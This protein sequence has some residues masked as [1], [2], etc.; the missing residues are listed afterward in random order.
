MSQSAG[1]YLISGA[2]VATANALSN[3]ST[4]PP[5]R[6]DT[7]TNVKFGSL[8]LRTLYPA[9]VC[10]GTFWPARSVVSSRCAAHACRRSLPPDR[11]LRP[12]YE[13]SKI[14]I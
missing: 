12:L 13:S 5:G 2:G 8:Q 7:A 3:A 4:S 11:S 6:S 10:S 1:D 9:I 14:P